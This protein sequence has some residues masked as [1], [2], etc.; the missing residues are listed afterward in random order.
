[1][2]INKFLGFYELRRLNIPTIDWFFFD[3]K[4]DKN[5]L[6]EHDLWTLRTAV[7]EGPDIWLPRAV[8]VKADEIINF[9]EK[10]KR[11]NP[12]LII[13]VY[14]FFYAIKSGNL[15]VSLNF[16]HLEAVKKDLWNLN[17]KNIDYSFTYSIL[18]M[19]RNEFGDLNFISNDEKIKFEQYGKILNIKYRNFLFDSNT[20]IQLEWSYIVYDKNLINSKE[21]K[22]SFHEFRTIQ[23]KDKI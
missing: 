5:Q 16:I 3:E 6:K 10:I 2:I 21:Y 14:P 8:G 9:A 15:N 20:E 12:E 13:I 22:L 7:L 1:M 23:S 17:I 18:D 11:N 19:S 4:F